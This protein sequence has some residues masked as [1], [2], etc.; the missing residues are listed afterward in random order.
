MRR[1]KV[2]SSS[3][4]CT[5]GWSSLSG[6]S[7]V[8]SMLPVVSPLPDPLPTHGGDAWT[9]APAVL[10]S[11]AMARDPQDPQNPLNLMRGNGVDLE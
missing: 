3:C 6:G 10:P 7:I 11:L 5:G 4:T 1:V 9:R 2:G 8:E